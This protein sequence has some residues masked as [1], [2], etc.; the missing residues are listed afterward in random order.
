MHIVRRFVPAIVLTAAS[1]GAF[2]T[3]VQ[4]A[5]A[6]RAPAF[7]D[8]LPVLADS[9]LVAFRAMQFADDPAVVLG[10][11]AERDALAAAIGALYGVDPAQLSAQWSA[12]D[13]AHQ[14]ALLAALSQIGVRYRSLGGSPESGFDCSGLTSWAW[15]RAG[16]MIAHQSRTQINAA[17]E[18]TLETANP[19]DLVFY[20]GHVMMYVGAGLMVHAPYTG[21]T[22]EID[23]LPDRSVRF[24]DPS[25]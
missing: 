5:P 21:K 7:T 4:A 15:A 10:Y 25:Y 17:Q 20:P 13:G 14:T 1:F 2:S 8:A 19:G 18:R 16:R 12:A 3:A 22:V 11:T 9:T 24:G 6:A 23:T